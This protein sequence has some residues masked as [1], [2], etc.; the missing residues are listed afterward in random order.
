MTRCFDFSPADWTR[1]ESDWCAWWAGKLER[2]LVTIVTRDPGT[3]PEPGDDFLTRFPLHKP[4]DEIID[5]F[6]KRLDTT[7]YYGDTSPK[8]W[9]NF[10]AGVVAAFLG[11]GVEYNTGTTW[12][13]PLPVSKLTDIQLAYD[14]ENAWWRRA[15]DITRAAVE[16]W[17]GRVLIA[18][19]DLGG[20]L[21]ILASLRGTENLLIDCIESPDTVADLV[22]QI[23]RL[24]LRYFDELEALMPPNQHGRAAWAPPWSPSRGYMLQSDFSYMISPAMFEQFVLPDLIACCEVLD[25]P[26]YHMDG[27][28]QLVHL[29]MLL[30]IEKLRGIQWQPGDGQPLADDWLDVLRRIQDGGKLCQVFVTLDGA[31]KITHELGGKGFL[32][33]ILDQGKTITPQEV[34][35]FYEALNRLIA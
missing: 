9:V 26:F 7:H 35:A 33:D 18:Y 4:A 20:N 29:D 12:F 28:G 30:S 25:Y 15:Q 8:W 23:T 11:S 13:R 10:G 19:T 24:W 3:Y 31:L 32:F 22:Q 2:P 6:Q 14:A 1:I 16:R 21:D 5:Y 17:A 34:D 27:K